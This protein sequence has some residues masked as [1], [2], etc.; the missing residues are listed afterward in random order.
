MRPSKRSK[1]LKKFQQEWICSFCN[2]K[3]VIAHYRSHS[4]KAVKRVQ[5]PNLQS[6]RGRPICTRCLRTLAK[7]A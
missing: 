3:A 4:M 1:I 5:K 2:K 6:Y 7:K